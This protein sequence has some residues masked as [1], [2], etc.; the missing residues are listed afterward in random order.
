MFFVHRHPLLLCTCLKLYAE[1]KSAESALAIACRL[2]DES[3]EG[4]KGERTCRPCMPLMS[5]LSTSLTSRCC[6]IVDRPLNDE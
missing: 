5:S 3:R 1:G 6:F 2:S 4:E